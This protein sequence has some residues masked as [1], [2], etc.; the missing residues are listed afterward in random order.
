[1]TKITLVGAACVAILVA[2]MMP[3]KEVSAA[4]GFVRCA[5]GSGTA[6]KDCV[7]VAGNK[8]CKKRFPDDQVR[9]CNLRITYKDYDNVSGSL[10]WKISYIYS[11]DIYPYT[12]SIWE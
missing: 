3:T 8:E 12:I 11:C 10:D 2:F 6:L 5:S 4:T 9:A 7:R 1:M